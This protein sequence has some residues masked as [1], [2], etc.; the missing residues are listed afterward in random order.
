[1]TVILLLATFMAFALID[2]LLNR[3]RVVQIAPEHAVVNVAAPEHAYI[4]GFLVP[5]NLRYHSGHTWVATE[6]K[7]LARVGIDEFGAALAGKIDAIELPKP[8]QWVRQGQKAIKIV[9]NGETTEL[10]SPVEGEIAAINPELVK[11]ASIVRDDP[12][13]AGWFFTV[14][15]P[16]E[17]NTFRNLIPRNMIRDWMAT[18]TERLYALQP[19]L[20]GAVAAD[21]GRPVDDL[22]SGLPHASWEGVTREFF[23][24]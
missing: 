8:G 20:A 11:N 4:D 19:Q 18:A 14:N 16:D 22:L 15:V 21:G 2:Y 12:Y 7:H 9:R 5:D 1:M 6:R 3:K 23:L 24:T 17:E 13:G 10:V